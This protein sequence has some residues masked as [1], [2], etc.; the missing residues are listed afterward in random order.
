MHYI[1]QQAGG[2]GGSLG[3]VIGDWSTFYYGFDR[4]QQWREIGSLSNWA[5]TH[6]VQYRFDYIGK[7]SQQFNAEFPIEMRR[8]DPSVTVVDIMV[9]HRHNGGW[10]GGHSSTSN[11]YFPMPV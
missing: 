7:M 3:N 2:I 4:F 9:N 5:G 8:H 1:N 6:G 10:G 11:G